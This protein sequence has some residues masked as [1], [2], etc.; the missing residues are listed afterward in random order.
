MHNNCSK[1]MTMLYPYNIEFAPILRHKTLLNYF[2]IRTIVSPNGWG[3]CGNDAGFADEG[4]NIGIIVKDNFIKE[5]EHCETVI[6]CDFV[7]N[8]DFKQVVINNMFFAI[9]MNKNV[10]C[11]LEL[12]K[13]VIQNLENESKK[14]GVYFKYFNTIRDEIENT[15]INNS[16][17]NYESIIEKVYDVKIPTIFVGGITEKTNKF[18]IQLSLREILLQRGFKV[19][20]IGTRAYSELLGF[21]SFPSFMYLNRMSESQ[22]I[23]SFNRFVKGIESKEDPDIFII[24]IPGSLM[25]FNNVLTNKFGILGYEI[26]QAVQPDYS[27]ISVLYDTFDVEFFKNLKTSFRYK[28]GFDTDC[29]NMSNFGFDS[30]FSKQ[31]EKMCFNLYKSDRVDI[32]K[33]KYKELNVPIYNVLNTED[34]IKMCDDLVQTLAEYGNRQVLAGDALE[35]GLIW[36]R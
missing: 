22:K 8:E 14:K 21:H 30:L 1:E 32:Q 16:E 9:K 13:E 5:L 28:F 4:D 26:A 36:S 29:F 12:S 11:T 27:I 17:I 31:I 20:Q 24:G 3:L 15:I 34:S 33:A 6:I 23:V 10:I 25:P 19:S 18:E 2:D 35:E 7:I